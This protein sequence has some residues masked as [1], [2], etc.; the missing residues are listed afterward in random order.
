[1]D[2]DIELDEDTNKA[3][4]IGR[5]EDLEHLVKL[6]NKA[7]QHVEY[8]LEQLPNVKNLFLFVEDPIHGD[9]YECGL[10]EKRGKK[11]YAFSEAVHD[12][13]MGA[14]ERYVEDQA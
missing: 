14:Y 10:I 12:M 5:F 11:A 3:L 7:W 1:M 13:V 6:L 4:E 2:I 8:R 9:S